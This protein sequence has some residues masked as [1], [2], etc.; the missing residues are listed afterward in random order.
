MFVR[1][2]RGARIAVVDK[3][4]F[5]RDIRNRSGHIWRCTR[6]KH[7]RAKFKISDEMRIVAGYFVHDHPPLD[8]ILRDGV[9]YRV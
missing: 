1:N 4:T 8:Y 5:Y 7:C 2:A 6:G 3:Y 9:Y